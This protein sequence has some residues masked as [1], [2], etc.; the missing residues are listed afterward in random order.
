MDSAARGRLERSR[1]Q[2]SSMPRAPGPTASRKRAASGRSGS[3]PSAGRWSSC[4]SAGRACKDL[5]L[6]DDADGRFYFKGEGDRTVWL[7]PHDEIATD[8]CDAAPEEID[9][10]TRSTGSRAWS[11][12]RSRR[13]SAAGRASEASRP[14]GCRST[15]SIRDAPGFFWCAGQGGFGIQTV[16]GRGEAGGCACCW[17]RSRMRWSR[18]SIRRFSRPRD[19]S[20]ERNWGGAGHASPHQQSNR[21]NERVGDGAASTTH[22]RRSAHDEK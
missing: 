8:P 1:R 6:V 13:S 18:T 20:N 4:E 19:S 3:S 21:A 15:A 2:S 16:A 5:P 7:S 14:T 22:L 10:A 9:V 17:A 12:G 11:T